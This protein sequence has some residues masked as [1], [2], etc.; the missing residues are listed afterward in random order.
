MKLH[1]TGEYRLNLPMLLKTCGYH[2]TQNKKGELSYV[3]A[4]GAGGYPRF[5]CYEVKSE[6]G[7]A[8]NVHLDQKQPTYG[9]HRAH[10][11]EY[12]GPVLE[13]EA[14]RIT[15]LLSSLLR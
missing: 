4:L 2:Q 3:R 10:S 9:E 13:A 8:I 1:F 6:K 11:G 7:F 5:H 15:A 14:K 12:E